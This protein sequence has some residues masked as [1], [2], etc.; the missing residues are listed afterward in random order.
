[1]IEVRQK[2]A[3]QPLRVAVAPEGSRSLPTPIT[4]LIKAWRN[5]RIGDVLELVSSEPSVDRDVKVWAKKSGNKL[6][7][8]SSDRGR[9]R[10][11]VRITKKGKESA[12]L[13]A[14]RGNIEDPDETKTT[15]KAEVRLLTIGGFTLGLRTLEPGW[16]W[17]TAMMPIVKTEMCMV[18]HLGYVLSG[19]MGFVMDDGSKIEVRPGDFFDIHPGHEA[20]TIGEVPAVFLDLMGAVESRK[21]VLPEPV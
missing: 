2:A 12:E 21:P 13:S 9:R 14:A 1:M 4:D 16:R 6:V 18:R 8:I 15:P 3:F 7:G 17:S 11:M 20:W 10:V 19:R 5:A